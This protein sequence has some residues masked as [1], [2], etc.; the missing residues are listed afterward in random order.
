LRS[1]VDTIINPRDWQSWWAHVK[2]RPIRPNGHLSISQLLFFLGVI[3]SGLMVA[4]MMGTGKMPLA[5]AGA[6]VLIIVSF[7]AVLVRQVRLEVLVGW[8]MIPVILS[9][10]PSKSQIG[11]LPAPNSVRMFLVA[12]LAGLI[13]LNPASSE[14]RK[15]SKTTNFYRAIHVLLLVITGLSAFFV[16]TDTVGQPGGDWA[17]T[18]LL[19]VGAGFV[20]TFFKSPRLILQTMANAARPMAIILGVIAITEYFLGASLYG[21]AMRVDGLDRRAPGPF[22]SAEVLGYFFSILAALVLYHASRLEQSRSSK[23]LNNL[24]LLFCALGTVVTFFRSGWFSLIAVGVVYLAFHLPSLDRIKRFVQWMVLLSPALVLVAALITVTVQDARGSASAIPFLDTL[25]ER[26]NGDSSQNSAGN[27]TTLAKSA[28]LMVEQ[29]PFTGVGFGQYPTQMLRY[30]PNNLPAEQFE[31]I[32]K[33]YDVSDWQ[34]KVAHNSYVQLVA[35]CGIP[36]LLLLVLTQAMPMFVLF[37]RRRQ[38]KAEA[39]GYLFLAIAIFASTATSFM[40]QSMLYY[41]DA[42]LVWTGLLLGVLMRVADPIQTW[43]TPELG[44]NPDDFWSPPPS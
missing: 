1:P 35:E 32:Y 24:A 25:Q 15:S 8:L 33:A 26:L 34:G 12:I 42:A 36:A 10:P 37:L 2:D 20:A 30:I 19:I 40:S 6:L 44:T 11:P 3:L 31:V 23:V 38:L 5:I 41:G 9:Y 14:E 21:L 29:F 43:N 4:T 16:G 22:Y 7:G 18:V 27:R 17:N 13:F 28:W 39:S